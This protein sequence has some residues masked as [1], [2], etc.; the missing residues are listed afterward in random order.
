ML[1]F[2]RG[3]RGGSRV[4]L[5][6]GILGYVSAPLWLLF[7]L[8]SAYLLWYQKHSGLS[9]VS[10]A[11][12]TPYLRLSAAHH[13]LLVFGLGMGVI[14]LPKILSVLDLC[15]DRERRRAFGGAGR[16]A[17]GAVAETLFSTLHA[18]L[19]M[20]YHTTFVFTTLLGMEVHWGTQ[21]RAANGTTWAAAFRQHSVHTAIGLG[22][23]I[24]A[25]QLGGGI[26]WWFLPVSAGLVFSIPFSVLTSRDTFGRVL[27]KAGL[28]LTPEETMPSAQL[29]RLNARLSAPG[30]N[31]ASDDD[32]LLEA[33]RD[34]YLN[35]I[36]VSMLLHRGLAPPEANLI[37]AG[38]LAKK[39]SASGPQA[40]PPTEQEL[41]ASSAENMA[42]L[43]R[44][45]GCT[46]ANRSP[47]GPQNKSR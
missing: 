38:T 5:S 22:W 11:A 23:G 13:A 44:S 10:V 36:H 32:A 43:H 46:L 33:I 42:E 9:D 34:P 12:F 15:W 45:I 3:F 2:T 28:L 20:V 30:A 17:I 31:F 21:Q 29:A 7:I 26:F 19:Q 41:L 1:L 39:L 8:V 27:R 4:H 37:A 35:A 14:F 25:W 18:P 40:L 16:A 24:F 47:E 6:Q